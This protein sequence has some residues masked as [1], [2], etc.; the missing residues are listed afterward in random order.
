MVRVFTGFTSI[1]MFMAC[2]NF[3]LPDAR[4]MHTWQGG[5]TKVNDVRTLTKPGPKPKL[6]LERQFFFV[7]VHQ[8]T[9]QTLDEHGDRFDVDASTLSRYF[10]AWMNSMYFKF[11]ELLV[12]SSRRRVDRSMP[13][14]FK[15]YY[16]STRI[17]IDY[18][19]IFV[20]RPS[21]LSQQSAGFSNYKN[22]T[23]V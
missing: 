6:S 22:H 11:K 8:R 13:E 7:C 21:S 14:C 12:F 2:F 18:T 16:P 19:E 15:N 17:I 20:E 10:T 5:R 3:L 23:T 9:G 4:T 1:A